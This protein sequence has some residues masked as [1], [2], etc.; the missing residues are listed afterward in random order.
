MD[1]GIER[2]RAAVAAGSSGLGLGAAKALAAEGARVAICGRDRARLDRALEEIGRRRAL[3]M[4]CDVGSAEGGAEFVE[5]AVDALGGPL[6]V[7]V[8]N[9]GGPPP[10]TFASTPV[11]AYPDALDL[12][13]LSIVGM[14]KAAVPGMQERGWGRVVAITSMSVRQPIPNL[15]LSNTARAGA[16]AFLKTLAL[17]VAG[18]GVTINSV[19]PGMHDTPRLGALFTDEQKSQMRMGDADDFGSIVTFL[20]SEQAK[21]V[22][23]LQ[24]HVD[25]GSFAGLQ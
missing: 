4:V 18:D 11:E 17:E 3:R 6:D 25:G 7:L 19:Q 2:R 22:T 21:Y 23:G 10:G 13:L 24:L 12:N 14:C 8:P 5:A 15:I 20:C 1:L 16:T 9:A